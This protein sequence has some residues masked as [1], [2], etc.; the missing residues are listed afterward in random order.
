[1]RYR[2]AEIPPVRPEVEEYRLHRMTNCHVG[3]T[4]CAAPP[5][6]VPTGP[7]GLRLR[8]ILTKFA[9]SHRLAVRPIQRLASDLF[10]LDNLLGTIPKLKRQVTHALD[11]VIA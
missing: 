8:A 9:G 5:G 1:M 2:I 11:P 4:N 3:A 10:V 7:I 6:G